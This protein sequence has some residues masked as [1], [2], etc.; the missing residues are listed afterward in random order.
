MITEATSI[1]PTPAQIAE[2]DD[3]FFGSDPLGYF[4]SRIQSL[5]HEPVDQG[6]D[7]ERFGTLLGEAAPDWA[8]VSDA[9]RQLQRAVDA[10]AVR[11]HAAEAVI[12]LLGALNTAGPESSVWITITEG[13]TR[14]VQVVESINT[15]LSSAPEQLSALLLPAGLLARLEDDD[16]VQLSVYNAWLWIEYAGKLLTW[17]DLDINAAHNKVKHG[18]AV[19]ARDDERIDFIPIAT[20]DDSID[21]SGGTVPLS[22]MEGAIPIFDKPLVEYL[23]RPPKVDGHRQ[24]LEVSTLQLDAPTLLAEAWMIARVYACLFAVAGAGRSETAREYEAFPGQPSPVAVFPMEAVVG[25]RHPVTL[26]P[27]GG[28]L[29][30]TSGIAFNGRFVGTTFDMRSRA[31]VTVVEG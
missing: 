20:G 29:T 27:G 16:V 12:R 31:T 17:D 13:P 15:W 6:R 25:M 30:R 3:T 5:L 2:L 18:L 24:G 10:F 7:A 4:R 28:Q 21:V 22:V 26:P 14:A 1:D 23:S 8:D 9:G 11:H 19:R